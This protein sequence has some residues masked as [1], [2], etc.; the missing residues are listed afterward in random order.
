MRRSAVD[1]LLTS[2]AMPRRATPCTPWASMAEICRRI[3]ARL[4][5]PSLPNSA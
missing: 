4:S 3:A 5:F 1:S 2:V